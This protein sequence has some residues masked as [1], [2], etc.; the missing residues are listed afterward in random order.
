MRSHACWSFLNS[1]H[2]TAAILVLSGWGDPRTI[3]AGIGEGTSVR[4]T[5]HGLFPDSLGRLYAQV[6]E[7]VGLRPLVDEARLQWLSTAGDPEQS[8]LFKR[9]IEINAK[10]LVHLNRHFLS[11]GFRALLLNSDFRSAAKTA[12]AKNIAASLQQRL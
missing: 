12:A 11:T 4:W 9:L 8:D 6:T 1:P 3:S 10:T 7:G 2:D 5:R